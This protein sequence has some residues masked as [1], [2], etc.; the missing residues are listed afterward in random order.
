MSL[1]PRAIA[2]QGVGYGA[3]LVALQGLV[4]VDAG[5]APSG[6]SGGGGYG[7]SAGGQ[8]SRSEWLRRFGDGAVVPAAARASKSKRRRRREEEDIELGGAAEARGL[9]EH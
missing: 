4:A 1:S 6:L 8:I 9:D 3:L 2:L 7:A 5:V